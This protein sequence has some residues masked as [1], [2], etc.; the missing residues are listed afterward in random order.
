[1]YERVVVGRVDETA[2]EIDSARKM[3]KSFQNKI[4]GILSA[5][6]GVNAI[7]NAPYNFAV[8]IRFKDK[9]DRELYRTHPLHKSLEDRYGHILKEATT[10][11]YEID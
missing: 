2:E 11:E 4:P 1:M 7:E 6:S 9:E 10:V 3:F 8:V 5:S